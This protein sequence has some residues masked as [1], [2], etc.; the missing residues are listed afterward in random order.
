MSHFSFIFSNSHK[1]LPFFPFYL[2]QEL[3]IWLLTKPLCCIPQEVRSFSSC[4]SKRW[5]M[6][7]LME[8]LPREG[9]QSPRI[10]KPFS[11][12]SL[13]FDLLIKDSV[14]L[15]VILYENLGMKCWFL[16]PGKKCAIK[17]WTL[18]KPSIHVYM[19]RGATSNLHVSIN[20]LFVP[21]L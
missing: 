3:L 9:K 2:I 20:L 6:F 7:H 18:T 12:D 8:L 19:P 1:F 17:M 5:H 10:T 13:R 16:S 14:C 21:T 15:K 4:L 11:S